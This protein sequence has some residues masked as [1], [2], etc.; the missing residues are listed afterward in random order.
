MS[1]RLLDFSSSTELAF[2]AEA[3]GEIQ[4][5]AIPLGI[6]PLIVGAFARDLHLQYAH[7][8]AT[9]R[10]TEDIDI[11]LQ[12]KGW[13]TF[14]RLREML[15]ET[16]RFVPR[17]GVAHRLAYRGERLALPIDIVPFGAV[18]GADRMIHWPPTGEEVMDVF[19]FQEAYAAATSAQL[20]GPLEVKVVSLAGLF[21]LKLVAWTARHYSA[22]RKDAHDL[23]LIARHYL[24]AGNAER[25]MSEHAEWLN[26]DDFDYHR[27]GARLLGRDIAAMMAG[28]ARQRF[29]ALLDAQTDADGALQL[30]NDMN[31][32]E[33]QLALESLQQVRVGLLELER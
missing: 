23:S 5:V 8:I 3:I 9:A 7:N 30:P 11:A 10:Q 32:Y 2:H 18:E 15:I 4:R 31:R 12:V 21:A 27:A 33:P 19:G 14:Q 1:K 28:A 25:L 17:D 29:V 6:T 26:E 16:K 24:D 13:A 20:P 22:P